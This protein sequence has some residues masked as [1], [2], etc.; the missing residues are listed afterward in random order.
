MHLLCITA[1][2]KVYVVAWF[3]ERGALK[4]LIAMEMSNE[5]AKELFL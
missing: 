3:Q 2:E 1:L 4:L 5:P